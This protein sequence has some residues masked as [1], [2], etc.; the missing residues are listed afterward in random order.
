MKVAFYHGMTFSVLNACSA[1]PTSI[2][3]GNKFQPLNFALR[4]ATLGFMNTS[5]IILHDQDAIIPSR[6]AA[7]GGNFDSPVSGE[8]VKAWDNHLGCSPSNDSTE[9]LSRF[10]GKIVLVQRGG[11]SFVSKVRTVQEVGGVGV[12][13]GDTCIQCPLMT[14]YAYGIRVTICVLMRTRRY[15]RY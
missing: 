9:E 7:F 11:C 4:R 1:M 10:R 12:I 2:A 5:D 13:V 3:Y 14:M 15:R 6:P 8:L